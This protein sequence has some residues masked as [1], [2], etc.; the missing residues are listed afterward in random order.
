MVDELNATNSSNEKKEILAKYPHCKMLLMYVYNPFWKYGVTSKNCLKRND[1]EAETNHYGNDIFKLLDDLKD[2]KIT[3]HDAIAAV[4]SFSRDNAKYKELIWLI[5]DR[6]LKTRTDAK[7][8]NKIW[9][10]HIP[11]FDVAL[12]NKYDEKTKKNVSFDGKWFVSRKLDGVRCITIIRDGDIKF[13][14]R[15]GN[16]FTTL[17]KVREALEELNITDDIV[18]DGELC[19]V[20]EDG[21]EDFT[22]AISQIKRKDYTIENPCYKL[23]DLISLKD[24]SAKYSD[25]ILS[26]RLA[27]INKLVP[28][29]HKVL[30]KLEQL[31]LDD[32]TFSDMQNEV[33]TKGWEG[34][35]LRKDD[36]YEGKRSKSMLKVKKFFDDEY[37]VKDVEMGKKPI[38]NDEGLMEE[39]D[40]LAAVKIEH[41]GEIVKVGSGWSDEERLKYFKNPEDI[42]GKTITVQYFE[43]SHDKD[44]KLSLRFPTVKFIYENGRDV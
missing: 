22:S 4:N 3:G 9:K 17:S 7:L 38:M 40:V 39:V 43:E 44:G 1:L 24:F 12:A 28:A 16:E 35:I 30:D 20:D 5:L 27:E 13:Y 26:E 37:V 32:N 36:V 11:S 14:S 23:F 33:A 6:N 41:K 15:A 42:I 2:R 10:N 8:I 19:I 21:N 31:R 34:L 25:K 29:G 18:L